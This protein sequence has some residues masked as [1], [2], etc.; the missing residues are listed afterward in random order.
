MTVTAQ[1]PNKYYQ[2][3][4][5]TVDCGEN[6]RLGLIKEDFVQPVLDKRLRIVRLPSPA[7]QFVFPDGQRAELPEPGLQDD[8][9]D[10]RQ[11]RHSEV[12]IVYP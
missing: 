4:E 5:T 9:T 12:K 10:R 3:P 1:E 8:D 11:M 6:P 2:H 7:P